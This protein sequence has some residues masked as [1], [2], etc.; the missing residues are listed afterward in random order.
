MFAISK[1]QLIVGTAQQSICGLWNYLVESCMWSPC[2]FCIHK[3]CMFH[4]YIWWHNDMMYTMMV[5]HQRFVQTRL[6]HDYHDVGSELILLI[7]EVKLTQ[8][9]KSLV[10]LIWWMLY[11]AGWNYKSKSCASHAGHLIT[12]LCIAD[13]F[14]IADWIQPNATNTGC[15]EHMLLEDG[16]FGGIQFQESMAMSCQLPAALALSIFWFAVLC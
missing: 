16:H 10:R 11:P 15:S 7:L 14:A 4:A 9:M 8:V 2:K 6:C 5:I 12:L 3:V 1:L 13:S